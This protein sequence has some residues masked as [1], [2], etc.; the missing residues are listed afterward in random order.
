MWKAFKEKEKGLDQFNVQ[1]GIKARREWLLQKINLVSQLPGMEEFEAIDRDRLPKGRHTFQSFINQSATVE[2][3]A[4]KDILVDWN[5]PLKLK[6]VL[7]PD[8]VT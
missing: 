1:L 2:V 6:L 4:T 7:L 5:V 3:S 8:C